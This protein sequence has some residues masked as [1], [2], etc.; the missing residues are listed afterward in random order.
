MNNLRAQRIQNSHQGS[1]AKFVTPPPAFSVKT[2]NQ[3]LAVWQV[4]QALPFK[5]IED[6]LLKALLYWL[7]PEARVYGRKWSAEE[8]KRFYLSLRAQ[9]IEK[10]LKVV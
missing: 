5:R 7:R 1:L 10:E 4:S 3:C 9:V 8:A 2:L 6:P